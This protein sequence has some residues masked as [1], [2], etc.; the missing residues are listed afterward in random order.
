MRVIPSLV[1]GALL[2]GLALPVQAQTVAGELRCSV[3]GGFGLIIA[4]DRAASCTYR[5]PGQPVEFYTGQTSTIGL[6]IGP[7]N[8]IVVTYRVLSDDPGAPAALQGDFTG[9]GIGVAAGAGFSGNVLVG[10][11]GGVTLVPIPNTAIS[12]YTGL[13][14][15]AG[16][17]QLRLQ[18]A[19]VEQ[20]PERSGRR[21]RAA[22]RGI[23]LQ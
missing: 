7:T 14:L 21:R 13:N 5:R 19:A 9:P 4:S 6:D 11:T 16:L 3:K 18:F 17:A 20:V 15:N 1:A 2:A 10:G 22:S 12:A 23:E 8:A